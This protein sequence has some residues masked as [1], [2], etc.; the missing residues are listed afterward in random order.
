MTESIYREYSNYLYEKYGEK[1]YKIPIK[2]NG[3]CPNRL[4]HGGRGCSFCGEDGG[5]FE[6]LDP[7]ISVEDQLKQNIEYISKKYKARKFIAYF[8]NYTNTYLDFTTFKNIIL[9]TIID[10]VV[11]VYISTRPDCVTN[12][13][14]E[15]LYK[16]KKKYGIEILLELGL[17]TANY[18]TLYSINRGHGL[19]EFIDC[20]IRCRTYD[21]KTC[22]HILIGL[23]SDTEVD[24]IET[25]RIVSALKVDQVKIHALYIVENTEFADEYKKGNLNLITKEEYIDLVIAF[26]RNLDPQIV[27]QRLIGRSPKDISLFSNWN[28]SWWKIKDNILDKMQEFN[29]RQGDLFTYL[30][31]NEFVSK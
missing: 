22:A 31:P 10:D 12:E 9:K 14:L 26:L 27:V 7:S 25:S 11:G 30:V 4:K 24:I 15:F 29:F 3:S 20:V 18:K 8:Q 1:V 23:P 16:L 19:A 2:L 28:T 6:N 17:Q 21:I 5:S 13:Q